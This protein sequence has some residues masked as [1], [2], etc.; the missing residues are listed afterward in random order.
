MGDGYLN[1]CKECTKQDVRERYYVKS[2]DE[3]W[4][5]KERARGREKFHR[6]GYAKSMSTHNV[7]REL[8]PTEGNTSRKLRSLGY[9]N[10]GKEAHHW[11]YNEPNSILLLSRK[12][13]RRLHLHLFVNRKD[14]YCYTLDGK[15]L[16]TRE[17]SLEYY[18]QI[19]SKYADLHDV[20]EIIDI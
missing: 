7:V 1:K 18:A 9:K 19:L 14:K 3:A 5:E 10:K 11:N 2:Q 20:L 16:D 17:K 6:L 12:A 4:M 15:R 13:H 8:N